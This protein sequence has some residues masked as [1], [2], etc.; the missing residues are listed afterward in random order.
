MKSA[1]PRSAKG[2]THIRRLSHDELLPVSLINLVNFLC[3]SAYFVT[4]ILHQVSELDL[5]LGTA[6]QCHFIVDHEMI[7]SMLFPA[8][9]I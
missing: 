1:F 3:A 2:A 9:N 5:I 7:D 6:S 8:S 4:G